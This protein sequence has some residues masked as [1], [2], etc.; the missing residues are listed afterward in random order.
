MARA[1]ASEVGWQFPTRGLYF[2]LTDGRET[3]GKMTEAVVWPGLI[4]SLQLHEHQSMLFAVGVQPIGL[5][6]GLL[7]VPE[8]T[9]WTH[10]FLHISTTQNPESM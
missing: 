10:S 2:G 9:I 8:R 3:E 4:T 7:A 6:I 1:F 5:S